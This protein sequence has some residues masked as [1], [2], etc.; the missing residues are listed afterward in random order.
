MTTEFVVGSQMHSIAFARDLAGETSEFYVDNVSVKLAGVQPV[1]NATDVRGFPNTATTLTAEAAGATIAYPVALSGTRAMSI[2]L[3][4]SVG[5]GTIE[6]THDGTTWTNVTSSLSTSTFVRVRLENKTVS[7][8][9]SIGL[10]FGTSGDA[11]IACAAQD[12]DGPT[13]STRIFAQTAPMTRAAD[14][15]I[16]FNRGSVLVNNAGTAYARWSTDTGESTYLASIS[17][18]NVDVASYILYASAASLV[19]ETR[20]YDGTTALTFTNGLARANT[21][22]RKQVSCWSGTIG[23]PNTGLRIIAEGGSVPLNTASYDTIMGA[24]STF[25]VGGTG[26]LNARD[27]YL[28]GNRAVTDAQMVELNT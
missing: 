8:P 5:T 23:G 22:L 9:H 20:V 19:T 18:L 27:I 10:R 15:G 13:V 11:V 14:S 25:T 6:F 17:V 3:K 24:A 1:L 28:W 2:D 4:R 21:A 26:F 7:N 12:E 16:V